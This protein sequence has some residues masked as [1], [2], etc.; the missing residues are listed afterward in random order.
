M[1]R[2][3]ATEPLM[4]TV[5]TMNRT[6]W[7]STRKRAAL[8]KDPI[9]NSEFSLAGLL[10]STAVYFFKGYVMDRRIGFIEE[11][12]KRPKYSVVD[13]DVE[14]ATPRYL[15]GQQKNTQT[16]TRVVDTAV[17]FMLLIRWPYL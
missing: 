2:A 12:A 16:T 11:E 1:S 13:T 8:A 14:N 7:R 10:V 3:T 4:N 5:E 9:R 6:I 17:Y 15:L